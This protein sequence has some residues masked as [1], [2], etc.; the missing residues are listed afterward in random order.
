MPASE[1]RS[2]VK[3]AAILSMAGL[4]GK[5]IGMFYRIWLMQLITPEGFAFYQSP[6][7]LYNFLLVVSSAGLPTAISR[8]VSEQIATGRNGN[9]RLVLR[10][11]RRILFLT[12][13]AASVLMAALAKP[14]AIAIG[15]PDAAPGFVALAP[16]IFFVCL[17]SSYRGYF[18][19]H[20]NMTPTAV[21]QVVEQLGKVGLGFGLALL[22]QRYGLVWGAVGAILGVTLSEALALLYIAL[23][24]RRQMAGQSSLPAEAVNAPGMERFYAR[25]F[26]IA[27]PVTIGASMMPIVSMVDTALVINQLKAIGYA[28]EQARALYSVFTG[29]VTSMINMPAVIT[30]SCSMALVPAIASGLA[31]GD[32]EGIRSTASTGIKLAFLLGSAVAVGMGLLSRQIIGL[33][34][35]SSLSAMQQDVGGQLLAVMS[36]AFL[37]LSIVQSTT[38]MLQGLGKPIYPVYTLLCGI[39]LKI[40]L[41]CVLIRVPAL[42]IL[43]AAISS[44]CCYAVAA[45]GNLFLVLRLTGARIDFGHFILRPAL[46]AGGMGLAVCA[47][48]LLL[49]L[50]GQTIVTILAVGVGVVVYCALALLLGC[51]TRQD[52]AFLPGGGRIASLLGKMHIRL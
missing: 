19:G 14:V 52:L 2:F 44:L 10:K 45:C 23:T 25:L 30:L 5:F 28:I 26:A 31:S 4:L 41:N 1:K 8:M 38:G 42:N 12:G 15:D 27:V 39:V 16:A 49:P 33:L 32:K 9:A 11:A 37:F 17:L 36:V 47:V 48:K 20:Q 24:A 46:A 13:L 3:G 35:H 7:S 18:Q 6:Y 51:L 40:V 43:G 22:L 21:S 50:L 29:A 34:F